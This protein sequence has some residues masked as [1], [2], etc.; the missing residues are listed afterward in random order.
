MDVQP[1]RSSSPAVSFICFPILFL[2]KKEEPPRGERTPTL[3]VFWQASNW[4]HSLQL[5]GQLWPHWT[6]LAR[7]RTVPFSTSFL[8]ETIYWHFGLRKDENRSYC[9]IQMLFTGGG[10]LVTESCQTL[11]NPMDCSPPGSS[12]HGDS[13]G[14]NTGVG[15]HSL[16]Q[17]SSQ[18]RDWTCI[19]CLAGRFFTTGPPGISI[20]KF[21]KESLGLKIFLL[22]RL[23]SKCHR[24]LTMKKN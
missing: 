18:Q 17:G 22:W 15:C 10:G 24:D 5:P 21:P 1:I 2:F 4:Y 13:P 12:V 16:L 14:K 6:H 11:C 8:L 3:E 7:V 19:Y 9:E 23:L 20:K